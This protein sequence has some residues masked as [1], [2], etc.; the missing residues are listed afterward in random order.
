MGCSVVFPRRVTLEAH[1]I[2]FGA[3]A[4][5]VRLVAVAAANARVIHPAL[6]ERAVLVI[7]GFD[8]PVRVVEIVVEQRDP[9]IVAER[10]TMDE[11]LVDLTAP[12]MASGAHP[13]L[14]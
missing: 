4:Q 1:A 2:A 11:I 14:A 5:A 13:D 7:F 12:G 8:L 9:V 10:L 6:D 3:Q